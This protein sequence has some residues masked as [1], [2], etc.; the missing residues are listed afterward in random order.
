VLEIDIKSEQRAQLL[1]LCG[2]KE[3]QEAFLPFLDGL[4]ARLKERLSE[5]G[6]P[7]PETE[8]LRGDIARIKALRR[9]ENDLAR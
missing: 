9:L 4:E 2:R 5:I 1:I 6:K 7:M 8:A 3:W